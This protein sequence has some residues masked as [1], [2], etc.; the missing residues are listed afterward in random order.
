MK[1]D[2]FEAIDIAIESGMMD[3]DELIEIC[4]NEGITYGQAEV[5]LYS[6]DREKRFEF[7]IG[8]YNAVFS[9]QN[10]HIATFN[11]FR[12]AYCMSDNIYSQ[13]T[14]SKSSFNLK[15]FLNSIQAQGVNFISL[16]RDEEKKY[17][18]GLPDL[19]KI[20][21]GISYEEHLSKE[22]GISWS[23]SEEEAKNYVYFGKN[24]V[25]KDKGGLI[26]KDIYKK[27]V[28]TVFYVNGKNE[29]VYLI[30]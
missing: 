8:L 9:L 25:G 16:M 30:K 3:I 18:D 22:Y 10:N 23:L 28:L 4:K 27:E 29:I 14:S 17:Y 5:F 19:I 7:F 20:Y 11:L 13:I 15:T 26:D 24:N 21:R 1:Q 6:F 2:L 12:E